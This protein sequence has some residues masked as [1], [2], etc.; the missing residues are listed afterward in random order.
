[1]TDEPQ[2]IMLPG[3]TN[4]P[5]RVMRAMSKPI[6]NHRGPEFREMFRRVTGNLQ[7]VFE[8]KND[9]ITLTS[10]GTGGV[11]CAISNILTKGEKIIIPVNGVFS[12]R[13]RD[14]INVYD[15]TPIEI[16]VEWG[17]AVT[18]EKIEEA[19]KREKDV[20]AVTIVYNETATGV[21]TRCLKEVGEICEKY[22][23][24]FIVDAISILGGD[25]LPVDE[26]KIDMCITGAQKSLMTP[27][28][29]AFVSVSP[30]AWSI[31]QKSKRRFYF[32][33]PACRKF[34]ADD[35]TP[36]TPALPLIYALDEALQMIKE[37]G[38]EPRYRRHKVCAD[39][40]YA[41]LEAMK[42]NL[43]AKKK[44]RSNVVIAVNNPSG[45]TDKDIHK[46]ML[47]KYRISIAGG[48][49]K[50]KNTMFRFGVMGMV[51]PANIVQTLN[52]LECTLSD[53]GYKM[54]LGSGVS[55]ARDVF[56]REKML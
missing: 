31:I 8:T 41:G 34:L 22:N 53:L 18:P 55:A 24:L 12:G 4:V 29:L 33:L 36:Y 2:L 15:G 47:E 54:D 46:R 45:I 48:M 26:W 38:L 6:I 16:P 23:A 52:A 30:K 44:V 3:P 11:E 51:N 35:E 13:V 43:Y 50:L 49:G 7:Y 42:L 37:E 39:A 10:S 28:G 25:K 5:P 19:L 21:T 20:R 40:L 1:V 32:D 56:T 17:D 9:V 27:P 14:T